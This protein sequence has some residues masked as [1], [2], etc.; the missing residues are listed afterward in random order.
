MASALV[1]FFGT[2]IAQMIIFN[3]SN[4]YTKTFLATTTLQF[5]STHMSARINCKTF[6]SA[7]KFTK[8]DC[9]NITKKLAE[10]AVLCF[11]F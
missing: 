8:E 10:R 5:V 9:K 6:V 4:S 1:V 2:P 11:L 3:Q 7:A